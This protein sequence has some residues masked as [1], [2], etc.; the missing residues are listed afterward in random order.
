[1]GNL[2]LIDLLESELDI[3][4]QK[5]HKSGLNYWQILKEVMRKCVDLMG[6]SEA[7][8]HTRGGR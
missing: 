6:Q 4:I 7:E 3:I 1:M 2:E 5:A 8:Y